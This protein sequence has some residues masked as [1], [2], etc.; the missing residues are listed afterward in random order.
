MRLAL[1]LT[2]AMAWQ[3]GGAARVVD[4]GDQSSIDE[5]RQVIART[6]EEWTALWRRHAP[7]RRPPHVDFDKEMVV[8]LFLGGRPT[9]GYSI[10]LV[11]T[12]QDQGALVVRYREGS[13]PPGLLTAQVL[14]FAYTL[15]ALPKHA[16][17]VRFEKVSKQ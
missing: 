3:A 16:G 15:V 8:G 11:G 1:A 13:P 2:A 6:A 14:T 7:D 9:A 17:E 12:A 10:E 5:P 4:R